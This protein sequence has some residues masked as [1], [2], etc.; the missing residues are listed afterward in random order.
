MKREQPG[1]RERRR[2]LPSRL[3]DWTVDPA[4]RLFAVDELAHRV[5]VER[6]DGEFRFVGEPGSGAGQFRYPRSLALAGNR[7]YVVD[8]WNHRVQVFT[9]P[10]WNFRSSFGSLGSEPGSLFCPS[11][12]AVVERPG[13][14]TLLAV[15]DRN[16][17]RLSFHEAD[18]DADGE[19]RFAIELD[20]P[21]FP[22]RVR[23]E[24]ASIDVQYE[25]G[26]WK[27]VA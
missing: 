20:G 21:W 22:V 6:S 23:Y 17:R 15:V 10:E 7:A 26:A 24:N 25:D 13:E 12:I 9:L 1:T 14:P 3:S 11:W 19:F 16:N 2:D 5:V 8:S 4:G 18:G 27:R